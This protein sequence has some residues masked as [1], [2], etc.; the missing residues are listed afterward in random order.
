MRVEKHCGPRVVLL[1][2]RT[3]S[4]S[5]A[6]GAASKVVATVLR[7]YGTRLAAIR[8]AEQTI[9]GDPTRRSILAQNAACGQIDAETLHVVKLRECTAAMSVSD[10][11][12]LGVQQN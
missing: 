6:L 3:A 1:W 9:G 5:S 2:E 12:S 4:L 7:S 10:V 8:E 11:Y